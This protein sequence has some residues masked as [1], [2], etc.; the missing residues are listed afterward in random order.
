MFTR[1]LGTFAVDTHLAAATSCTYVIKAA[2][3]A[4]EANGGPITCG[5]HCAIG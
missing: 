3:E 1:P 5:H 2:K 4:S